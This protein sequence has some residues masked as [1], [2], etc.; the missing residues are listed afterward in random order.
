MGP[1]VKFQTT[2]YL[3]EALPQFVFGPHP[4]LF[5]R[6][7]K[8]DWLADKVP[9]LWER[10]RLYSWLTVVYDHLLIGCLEKAQ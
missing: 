1:T 2:T 5:S 3:V 6:W 9:R 8:G 4:R 10:E 7:E